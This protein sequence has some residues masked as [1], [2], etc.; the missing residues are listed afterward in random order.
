MGFSDGSVVKN[1][2]DSAGDV[3]SIPGSGRYPGERHG[4][5]LEFCKKIPWTEEPTI[6]GVTRESATAERLNNN[7]SKSIPPC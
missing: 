6:N 1:P 4:N 5:P 7:N 3:G 2:P